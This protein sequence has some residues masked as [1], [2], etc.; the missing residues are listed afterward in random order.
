MVALGDRFEILAAV[1][2]AMT[3]RIPIAHIHGGELTEGALDDGIRHAIT[4]MSQLHFV[5][6]G[7]TGQGSCRWASRLTGS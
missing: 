6:A 7:L 5:A 4:K 3:A 2:A 1:I